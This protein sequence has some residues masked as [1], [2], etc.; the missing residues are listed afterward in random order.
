M[1]DLVSPFIHWEYINMILYKSCN[2]QSL[3][4]FIIQIKDRMLNIPTFFSIA[5]TKNNKKKTAT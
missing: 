5:K 2:N 3:F 4:R 1:L